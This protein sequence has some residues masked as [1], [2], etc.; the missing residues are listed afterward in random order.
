M[1][2]TLRTI[3]PVDGRLYVERKFA[4]AAEISRAVSN[5]R[6]AQRDWRQATAK[7]RA[8][9][10]N[11]FVD[12][13]SS[14]T[15][16]IAEEIS[17]Q[18]GRPIVHSPG[19]VNGVVERARYMISAA[20]EALANIEPD[21]LSGFRRFIRREPLGVILVIAP[22]NY[23]Y[24]TAINSLIAALMSGNAVILKPSSQT[25]LSAERFA[26]AFT[27]A[28]LPDGVFQYLH[29]TRE[30]TAKLI[31]NPGIDHVMFTG[32]VEGGKTIKHAAAQRFISVGLELGGKDPAYVRADAPL[33][34]TAKQLVDGAFYNAG[35]SCCAVERI[36]VHEHLFDKFVAAFVE[37]TRSLHLGNPLDPNTTLG[38]VVRPSAAAFVQEQVAE[39]V[40][41]GAR[42]W[43]DGQP[44]SQ[45]ARG[46]AYLA[47]Q[48]LTDVNHSM[49][50]MKEET[51][52]PAVGIMKV[53][54]DDEAVT[55]MNDSPF[56]LTGSVWT[57]DEGAALAIGDQI[58]T[59]TW[60]MNRCDYLDPA[61]AWTGVK[62]SGLGCTLSRVGY[63]QLTRPK[64]FHMRL[65]R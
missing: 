48:V 24:L 53:S 12:A 47:P 16:E 31:G 64:S 9:W 61:L 41:H 1:N 13:F 30:A 38:P 6:R 57:S 44:N 23:P 55:L 21:P 36:Y 34:Y 15:S 2:Q 29:L 7:M 33:E 65:P 14:R 54:S 63:E 18:M 52:G 51:F 22:W 4:T 59:G 62:D 37:C 26:Q 49:R 50:I 28:G 42:T 39:A 60:Y 32:S 56:G 17:W 19:E 10:C 46:A 11:L 35:Q 27:A 25:P 3:S 40:H 20:S 43:I 58:H 5:G 45:T 8:D